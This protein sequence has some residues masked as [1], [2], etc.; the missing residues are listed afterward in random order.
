MTHTGRQR[1]ARGDLLA[2]TGETEEEKGEEKKK[3][4]R[5]KGRRNSR[6]MRKSRIEELATASRELLAKQ[7]K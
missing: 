4:M 3:N 2:E 7:E 1:V 5:R 6:N